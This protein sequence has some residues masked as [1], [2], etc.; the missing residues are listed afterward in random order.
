M[1]IDRL[2]LTNVGV[3]AGRHELQLTPPSGDKPVTVI[4]GLNGSGK[5]TILEA[6]LFALYGPLARSVLGRAGSYDSYLRQLANQSG[7]GSSQ[8]SVELRFH[9]FREG[10]RFDYRINRSWRVVGRSL[11]EST[12]VLLNDVLDRDLTDRWAEHVEAFM[13]RGIAE[14]FFFDGEKIENLAE[15]DNARSMLRTVIG[16]LLGLDLVDR[17]DTDLGV[18][19]R[20]HRKSAATAEHQDKIAELQQRVTEARLAEERLHQELAATRVRLERA[21][22]RRYEQQER[23]R[24]EGGELYHRRAALEHARDKA[25]EQIKSTD[26][27]LREIAEGAGPFMLVRD[28]LARVT[29]RAGAEVEAAESTRLAEVLMDR[30]REIVAKLREL[31]VNTSAVEA[32]DKFLANERLDRRSR[33]NIEAVTQLSP[34][35]LAQARSLREHVL[36]EISDRRPR[37]LKGRD[38]AAADLEDAQRQLAA[39]PETAAVQELEA[40]LDEAI[41]AEA[42]TQRDLDRAEAE[43]TAARSARALADKAYENALDKAAT[44][45]LEIE[46]SQR[47][48]AH[49]QRVRETLARF[50]TEAVRRHLSRIERLVLAALRRLLRKH[51]LIGELRIDPE[52]FTVQVSRPDGSQL[53]PQQLS[54]GERQLLAVALLWGLAQASG[55]PLPIVIDTPL[56]RLDGQHRDHLINR[57]FP[58]ASHQV[59]L[60]S[61]DQEIDERAWRQL[62]PKV[63]HSYHLDH[64]G[65][66]TATTIRPGYFW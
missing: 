28:L 52:T 17:L 4:G 34:D 32:L 10:Q 46:D 31:K 51:D 24:V 61:T 1:I 6:I 5:T 40:A 25:L 7:P 19:E 22:K 12:T 55:R 43:L 66:S 35:G 53:A 42:T 54:A 2:T 14:L 26:R 8:A 59:I 65:N 63:G 36:P 3:F 56:G 11:R 18:I 33:S 20:N 9:A 13:P 45:S 27:H 29:E 37:L 62:E 58:N 23:F 64:P 50:R 48:L 39:V 57:Y 60:L 15:L 21:A 44:A 49:S 41:A 30:D 38:Q 16:A 47:I